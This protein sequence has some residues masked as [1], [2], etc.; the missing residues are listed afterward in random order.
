[1]RAVDFSWLDGKKVFVQDNYFESY[2][3][4]FAVG[5]IRERLSASGALLVAT[6]D[7]ADVIVELRSGVLSEHSTET[8]VG[9]PSMGLPI[10]LTG[11]VQTPELALYKSQFTDSIAKFVLFAYER[12]TGKYI[13]ATSPMLGHAHYHYYRIIFIGWH[14]TDLPELARISELEPAESD[15]APVEPAR[16]P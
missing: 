12:Q 9:L 5:E 14:K 2:D 1:L 11:P 15:P 6:N 13:R 4:G 3:K 10:P 16:R 8:L 7:K